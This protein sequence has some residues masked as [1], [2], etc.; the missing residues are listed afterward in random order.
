ML[1]QKG[2]GNIYGVKVK[3]PIKRKYYK[4]RLDVKLVAKL[5][6]RLFNENHLRPQIHISN[7]NKAKLQWIKCKLPV[8]LPGAPFRIN[9]WKSMKNLDFKKIKMRR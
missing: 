9:S 8:L 4:H 6:T 5:L 1:S 3:K 7:L 2:L